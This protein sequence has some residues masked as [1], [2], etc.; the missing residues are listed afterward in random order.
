MRRVAAILLAVCCAVLGAGTLLSAATAADGTGDG[1]GVVPTAE[2]TST[3]EPTAGSSEPTEPTDGPTEPTDGPTDQP[4][5][6]PTDSTSPTETPGDGPFAVSD[7]VFRWGVNDESNNRAF[8][9]GTFNFLS[10]G[11]APDP[12]SGGQTIN[13]NNGTWPNGAVAWQATSGAVRIEKVT[14]S[15]ARPADLAG[16]KTAADDTTPLSTPT[17]GLFSNHQVVISGGTGKVDPVA[18]TARITWQGSF[19]VFF[20][21]GMTFFSISNPVLTVTPTSATITA[22]A[23]GFASS[24]DDQSIWLP[25]PPTEVTLADLEG[26]GTAQ[27]S[28]ARGFTANPRYLQVPHTP[29]DGSQQVRTGAFWG[30]FPSSFLSFVEKAGSGAYW[31]SSGGAS[32]AYKVPKPVLISW[33]AK[34]AIQPDKAVLPPVAT[35]KQ[36]KNKAGKKPPAAQPPGPSL[37]VTQPVGPTLP[38]QVFAGAA[39]APESVPAAAARYEPPVAYALTSAPTSAERPEPSGRAWEWVLGSLLLLGAVGITVSA[40]LMRILKGIR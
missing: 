31:Y 34:S 32:D 36:P 20:Y 16:L 7:A 35:E 38:D 24:M 27:L 10:A 15:G 21:S 37:P 3:T 30:A 17:G 29:A 5:D 19:T 4:T 11:A 6:Q 40:P 23:S 1:A 2:S 39:G 26:I 9:P 33:D 13:L 14:T 8:A 25:V 22:T 18:G 12:G 28:A